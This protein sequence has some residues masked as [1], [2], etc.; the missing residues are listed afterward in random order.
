MV[1]MA[2]KDTCEAKDGEQGDCMCEAQEM[3]SYNFV[4]IE[5][6]DGHEL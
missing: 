4:Q 5:R 1:V 3:R 6:G 2:K